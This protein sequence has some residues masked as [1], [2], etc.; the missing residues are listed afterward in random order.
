[1]NNM[2]IAAIVNSEIPH[3]SLDLSCTILTRRG[4]TIH[5]TYSEQSLNTHTPRY[6]HAHPH[7]LIYL[8]GQHHVQ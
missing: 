5:P 4:L 6:T 3:I 1:M 8:A 7:T 2:K